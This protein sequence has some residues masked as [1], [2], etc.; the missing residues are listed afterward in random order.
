MGS[1]DEGP[2]SPD[3]WRRLLRA[4]YDYPDEA[5]T[6][7]RRERR[8][9]R[10]ATRHAERQ[11]TKEWIAEE[12]RR[13][14][15]TAGGAILVIVV[16]LGIGLAV[17][18]LLPQWMNSG[19]TGDLGHRPPRGLGQFDRIPFELGRV[20]LAAIAL[21][22]HYLNCFLRD[23]PS[24]YQAVQ[25]TGGTSTDHFHRFP[26][27]LAGGAAASGAVGGGPGHLIY[28]VLKTR[29]MVAYTGASGNGCWSPMCSYP[30]CS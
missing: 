12:R 22:T 21:R 4:D 26:D 16:I 5:Y 23:E 11:N 24:Q 25:S 6:G 7:S 14:P 13:D 28:A 10:R 3:E 1:K 2:S 18:Y 9:I 29:S 30:H 15:V 8:R 20:P 27:N 19:V 17:K